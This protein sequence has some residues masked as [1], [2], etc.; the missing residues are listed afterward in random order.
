[1]TTL[2][3]GLATIP[4]DNSYERLPERFFARLPP[5]PVTAPC[6]IRVNRDLAETLGLDADALAS[7]TGLEILAG[8]SVP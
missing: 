1:M 3:A 7:P 5:T 4:F 6:L 8:N 2:P